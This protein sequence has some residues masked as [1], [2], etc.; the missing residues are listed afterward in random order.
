[1]KATETRATLLL[2]IRDSRDREAWSDF[3]ALYTPLIYSYGLKY[4]LQDADA[5]DVA[6]ETM[7]NLVRTIQQFHY[8]AKQGSF[9]GWLVTVAR[10][11]IRRRF[12]ENVKKAKGSGKTSMLDLLAQ[13]P[14]ESTEDEWEREYQLRTFHWAAENVQA[15]F[16]KNTW[17]AF[18][19]TT[20]EGQPV[21]RVAI[22]L[23]ITAGAV[24][25]ARSRV[26]ARIKSV[27]ADAERLEDSK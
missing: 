2:R 1:M 15:E 27:I 3:V 22:L 11:V 25:I 24:Y 16:R 13:Q 19:L 7:C 12:N 10:N 21:D 17:Q 5:A 4:G 23:G 8:D 6:Q 26:L 18:W 14:A 20:V 9:R